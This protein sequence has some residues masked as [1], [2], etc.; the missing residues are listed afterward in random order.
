MAKIR[1]PCPHIYCKYIV[2]AHVMN[3]YDLPVHIRGAI[4]KLLVSSLLN[5]CEY[6]CLRANLPLCVT[7][8]LLAII[9]FIHQHHLI[10]AIRIRRSK[11]EKEAIVI[12]TV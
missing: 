3:N 9:S 8:V 2:R 7:F 1:Q 6:S 4:L 12:E 11:K 10:Y 5:K